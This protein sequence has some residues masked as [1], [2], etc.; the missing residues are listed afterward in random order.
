MSVMYSVTCLPE[1]RDLGTERNHRVDDE[2]GTMAMIG[3]AVNTHLSAFRRRD[4]FLDHQLDG[5]GHRLQDAVRSDTHRPQARLCPR[6][7]L[8]LEQHHVGDAHERRV[9]HDDDLQQRN[10]QAVHEAGHQR[11]TSPSTMSMDPMSATTSAMRCP[12]TR[13]GSACRLQNDGGRTRKRY[14]LVD[15]PS[16]TMK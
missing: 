9:Q 7:D 4:V 16:L 5:V 1:N 13:R 15:F 12:R 10:E 2:R 3:A 14:G 11:S 6:D 8:A